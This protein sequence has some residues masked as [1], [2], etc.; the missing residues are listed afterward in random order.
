MSVL[1]EITVLVFIHII[2][3]ISWVGA[4]FFEALILHVSLKNVPAKAKY[5]AYSKL[6]FRFNKITGVAATATLYAGVL[7]ATAINFGSFKPMVTTAWGIVSTLFAVF[8]LIGLLAPLKPKMVS[9]MFNLALATA[10]AAGIAALVS[11]A[12]SLELGT[13]LSS[14]WG[15]AIVSGALI[16]IVLLIIG[17]TQGIKRVQIAILASQIISGQGGE[18]A[19][20]SL[21]KI[22]KKML[23]MVIPEN[24]VALIVIALMVYAANPF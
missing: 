23:R 15:V 22:E 20:S 1:F 7:L 10:S 4:H 11:I 18:E 8:L 19:V 13:V 2:A 3:A 6:L 17:A 16:A 14:S 24:I 9:N 5:E 21:E 12:L